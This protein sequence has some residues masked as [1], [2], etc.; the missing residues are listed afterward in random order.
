MLL[1]PIVGC[2]SVCRPY[3][4]SVFETTIRVVG[5][6]LAAFELS[7]DRMF[8]VRSGPKGL[9][10]AVT[11]VPTSQG[12]CC[13]HACSV[14]CVDRMHLNRAYSFLPSWVSPQKAM[15]LPWWFSLFD[16]ADMLGWVLSLLVESVCAV[17]CRKSPE[18]T[19]AIVA[20]TELHCLETIHDSCV[21]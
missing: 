18:K 6:M 19:K 13:C 12:C 7:N 16:Q 14:S 21:W 10:H 20:H 17:S 8:I 2:V 9:L 5:G 1:P 11:A 3:E 4:A 15:Q